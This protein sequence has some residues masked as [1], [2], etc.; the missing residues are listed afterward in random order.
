M[1]AA[2]D[3]KAALSFKSIILDNDTISMQ[4]QK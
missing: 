2:S 1:E 3:I 4:L